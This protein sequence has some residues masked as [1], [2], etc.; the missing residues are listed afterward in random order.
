MAPFQPFRV[1]LRDAPVP[2]V[3]TL[4]CSRPPLRGFRCNTSVGSPPAVVCQSYMVLGEA[5]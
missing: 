5:G 1:H 4:E 2:R 3:E